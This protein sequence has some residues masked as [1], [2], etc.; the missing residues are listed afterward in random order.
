MK[1]QLDVGLVLLVGGGQRIGFTYVI[2]RTLS[3]PVQLD[4]AAAGRHPDIFNCPIPEDGEVDNGG[5]RLMDARV[6]ILRLPSLCD[7]LLQQRGVSSET[8]AQRRALAEPHSP[9]AWL[10][11]HG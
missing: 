3:R 4:V 9:R 6:D 5:R 1:P 10:P 7:T 2:K 11:H 8:I